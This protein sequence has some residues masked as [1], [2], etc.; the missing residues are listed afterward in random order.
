MKTPGSLGVIMQSC[1]SKCILR[2]ERI[3]CMFVCLFCCCWCSFIIIFIIPSH[4][5]VTQPEP[6]C[7]CVVTQPKP[8][9][10]CWCQCIA[11]QPKPW[12]SCWCQCVVTQP[13]PR[14]CVNLTRA[15]N[16]TIFFAVWYEPAGW[17]NDWHTEWA[18]GHR[19]S[20]YRLVS[21]IYRDACQ[22]WYDLVVWVDSVGHQVTIR[23]VYGVSSFLLCQ[24]GGRSWRQT[25]FR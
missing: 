16:L 23:P 21:V 7:Q 17:P 5:V 24:V 22:P 6:R 12:C 13:K 1:I 18:S 10:S 25:T 14:R 3:A 9:C 19:T 2:G 15:H 8:L 20:N 11:T 4:C